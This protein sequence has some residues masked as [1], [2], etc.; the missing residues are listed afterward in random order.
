MA[1]ERGGRWLNGLKMAGL[2][3]LCLSVPSAVKRLISFTGK[4]EG[5]T[6]KRGIAATAIARGA[7][8]R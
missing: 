6:K 7:E 2:V 8:Q 1:K 3:R 5:E 4:H